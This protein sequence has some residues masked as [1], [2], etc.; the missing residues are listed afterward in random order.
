MKK[1]RLQSASLVHQECDISLKTRFVGRGRTSGGA[2][3]PQMYGGYRRRADGVCVGTFGVSQCPSSTPRLKVSWFCGS[4]ARPF[5][6]PA[7]AAA[8]EATILDANVVMAYL[9][10]PRLLSIT[11]GDPVAESRLV[12]YC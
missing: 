5:G 4:R 12:G 9:C 6:L 10:H 3:T 8:F 2:P 1:R 7:R 11:I